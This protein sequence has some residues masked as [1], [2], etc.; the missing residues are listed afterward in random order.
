VS[1]QVAPVTLSTIVVAI[2]VGKTSAML[3]VTDSARNRLFGPVEFAMTR[4]ELAAIVD[5]V[6]GV[7]TPCAQVKVGI[8]AA[9]HY[10]RPVLDYGWPPGWEVVELNP[11]HV[12][13]QRR[14]AGRRRV[15]TDAI[16]LEA[17]TELVLAGRGQ[18]VAAAQTL[19]GEI[20]AWA[21]HRSRR[22]AVRTATK[23]QLLGQL[24]RAFPGLTAALPDVLGTKIGR[25]I[26]A[27]FADPAR[28]TAM[29]VNRLIRFAAARDV[30]L[31]RPVAE[32]LVT[33][34]HE[35]L[36]TAD[37]AVARRVLAADVALLADLDTQIAAAE[38]ELAVLVPRSPFSTLTSVPGWGVIRIANYAAALGDPS[39]WPGPRQI[40]RAS[41]LSPM[42]YE[43][44]GKR[45]DGTI[46]REGSV[47]LRRALIDLGMGLWLCDPAAKTY[48]AGLKA[49]GKHGGI[50]ACALAHRATRI[51]HALV[52]DHASYDPTRW[53]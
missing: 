28:L 21:G 26:A 46:S 51:T 36:S 48:A 30:Q 5:R 22:V 27:E 6:G 25:L 12:A 37:A 52:R 8:E 40:Y 50:I 7:V 34:A 38:A 9:G 15:K 47:A 43:S 17:I 16:D 29:G 41:G 18:S 11:A 1:V 4:G 10:H 24:D 42:Q 2:D 45:R 31:R 35:A 14:V 44:A 20:S 32:R 39:R 53:T 19:F 23:N 13:E 49:R 3:S 33:A